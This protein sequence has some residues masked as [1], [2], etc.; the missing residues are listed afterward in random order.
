MPD[1]KGLKRHLLIASTAMSLGAGAMEADAPQ[2]DFSVKAQPVSVQKIDD[3]S[4]FGQF[5]NNQKITENGL[6]F[7]TPLFREKQ[8]TNPDL[9]AVDL[10]AE[11][12][13]TGLKV[14][15]GD[16]TILVLM[17]PEAIE[18]LLGNLVARKQSASMIYRLETPQNPEDMSFRP[19]SP[20]IVVEENGQRRPIKEDELDTLLDKGYDAVA[21]CNSEDIID[22]KKIGQTYA[23][24]IP[25]AKGEAL[26]SGMNVLFLKSMQNF[27]LWCVCKNYEGKF[28]DYLKALPKE[29]AQER[30]FFDAYKEQL[31]AHNRQKDAQQSQEEANMPQ[32]ETE[33]PFLSTFDHIS[34]VQIEKNADQTILRF[35]QDQHRVEINVC[36][37]DSLNKS[38]VSSNV[39]TYDK[40][41][42]QVD[43]GE[44]KP[45]ELK[46][47][48]EQLPSLLT[49][50]QKQQLGP[51]FFDSLGQ[52]TQPQ[53]T[54]L[55]ASS[56]ARG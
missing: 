30:E 35:R 52:K 45:T 11:G 49:T 40:S 23:E 16:K 42:E 56:R 39:Y 2:E 8:K 25:G 51:S 34:D 1:L 19:Y 17:R 14:K 37:S 4:L 50:E 24:R 26:S 47:L 21:A 3:N 18:W 10:F 27:A 12:G 36:P 53:L 55:V 33:S 32:K 38:S 5:L 44:L 48:Q 22:L 54:M 6:S 31:L 29:V 46:K 7:D 9:G 20:E 43:L 41:G 13:E 15:D 28:V